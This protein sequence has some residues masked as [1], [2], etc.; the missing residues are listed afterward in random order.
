MILYRR[1]NFKLLKLVYSQN[2]FII[3]TN[4]PKNSKNIVSKILFRISIKRKILLY[5]LARGEKY[6]IPI[7]NKN[8]HETC[9]LGILYKQFKYES[10]KRDLR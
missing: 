7:K 1:H 2:S 9:L 5:F 6:M 8:E 10:S 4:F 3:E